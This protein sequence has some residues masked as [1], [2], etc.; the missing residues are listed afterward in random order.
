MGDLEQSYSIDV[1]KFTSILDIVIC[2][3]H[4]AQNS[5]DGMMG[6]GDV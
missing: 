2:S 3:D 1:T 4:T 5:I 6:R